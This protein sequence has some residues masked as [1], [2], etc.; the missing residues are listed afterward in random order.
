[1]ASIPQSKIDEIQAAADIVQVISR[2]VAL[3]KAG[4]NLK[5][6]C[7]FHQEK[8][9]S[10]IVSPEKQIYHCFG[11]GK[12]GNVFNFLMETEK[13]T[14]IEVVRNLASDY[15]IKLPRHEERSADAENVFDRLYLANGAA[16]TFYQK[17]LFQEANQ[18][19]LNYLRKRQLSDATVKKFGI[20]YAPKSWDS[21]QKYM[22]KQT[23][24]TK[25]LVELGLIQKRDSGGG[26]FDKFRNRIMFPFQSTSGRF[27]GFGG[28]RLVES[29]QPKYLNSPESEIYRKGELLYG[30]NFAITKIREMNL[31]I[32]VE[33]YFDLLRL[34]DSGIENVVASS[35]TAITEQ[36]GRLLKRYTSRVLIAYD[37]DEAGISAAIR[38][39]EILEQLELDVYILRIPAPH[40]PDSFIL[41]NGKEAFLELIRQRV[42]PFDMKLQSITGQMQEL[43]DEDKN[44][45]VDEMLQ[46]LVKLPNEIKIGLYIHRLSE[47]MEIAE[48][49]LI[50]RFN[51]LKQRQRVGITASE[52]LPPVEKFRVGEW[53]AE[54]NIIALLL[55]NESALSNQILHQLSV[56]DF[57]NEPLR[58]LFDR[59]SREWE[60]TGSVDQQ[61]LTSEFSHAAE[62]TFLARLLLLE[63]NY[64]EKLAADCIY[65]LRKRSL[66]KRFN[67]IKRI[68]NEESASHNAV[69]HYLK[70]LTEI[71]HKLSEIEKEHTRFVKANL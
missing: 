30:L 53:Q 46:S 56:A 26:Y 57:E 20:G 16:A 60:E 44:Q 55:L 3:K 62:G 35:G 14:F 36:Q 28:R 6:L 38:N 33:G 39:S 58:N 65:R 19:P 59:I 45:A 42:T 64:P 31:V 52:K 68:M 5:G 61:R 32:L 10:F 13:I 29:D 9:P 23:V 22:Q 49:F 7:P 8:T 51:R 48:N 24:Q 25:T 50:A 70:E 54:E 67:E 71:R 15:G 41:E 37:S 43:S 69:M 1:M 4:K 2:Y 27:V 47:K 34:A 12:G 40:D 63:I 11:C 18:K 66:D 17:Q 21:L